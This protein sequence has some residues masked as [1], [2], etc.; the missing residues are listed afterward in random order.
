M[1]QPWQVLMCKWCAVPSYCH[2]GKS[3]LSLCMVWRRTILTLHPCD[4]FKSQCYERH[5]WPCRVNSWA[6]CPYKDLHSINEVERTVLKVFL[7]AFQLIKSPA[8]SIFSSPYM[9]MYW[10]LTF[11]TAKPET[12]TNTDSFYFLTQWSN[13]SLVSL[14]FTYFECQGVVPGWKNLA[15]QAPKSCWS[16][17][18]GGRILSTQSNVFKTTSKHLTRQN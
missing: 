5:C 2:V 1:R 4:G 13:S 12:T 10:R 11:L 17:S 16:W 8:S 14:I 15:A 3:S 18:P 9:Y 7:V 6:D